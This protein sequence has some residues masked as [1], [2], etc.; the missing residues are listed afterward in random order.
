MQR[1]LFFFQNGELILSKPEQTIEGIFDLKSHFCLAKY[2]NNTKKSVYEGEMVNYISNGW[3]ITNVKD[4]YIYKGMHA[5]G[6]FSGYGEVYNPDG[7]RIFGFF[8]KSIRNGIS[9]ALCK[10]GKITFGKY[11]DDY[12]DGPFF[13]SQK[14]SMRIELWNHGYKSKLIEKL[15]AG[16]AYFKG[17]YPEYIWLQKFDLKKVVDLF[18]EVKAEEYNSAIPIPPVMTNNNI[19]QFQE[20]AKSKN[21]NN[22]N[23]SCSNPDNNNLANIHKELLSKNK[24]EKKNEPRPK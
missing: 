23:T 2:V 7:S 12:R 8:K 24:E 21:S 4:N 9:L 10:D 19:S 20:E 11:V 3:G 16:R 14:G 6:H 5:N 13:V 1:I 15:D 18:L 17:F 22:Q